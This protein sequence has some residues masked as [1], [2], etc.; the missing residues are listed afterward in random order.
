MTQLLSIF[1]DSRIQLD[2]LLYV[3]DNLGKLE[4]IFTLFKKIFLAW[5]PHSSVDE[6]LFIIKIADTKINGTGNDVLHTFKS[7][8]KP[9][10]GESQMEVDSNGNIFILRL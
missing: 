7:R 2:Y 3:A 5:F 8:M 9:K 6:V 1:D 4:F 10:N